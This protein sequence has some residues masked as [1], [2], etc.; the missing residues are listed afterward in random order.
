MARKFIKRFIPDSDW[1]KQQKSLQILGVW[2]HDPNIWHLTRHSVATAAFIGFFVAFIPL[3]SQMILAALLAVFLRANL[4]ISVALVWITNPLTMAPIYYIAYKVG[5]VIL[6]TP[7]EH[8]AFELSWDWLSSG[9]THNWQPFLLGCLLC[10]L[11]FGLLAS[12]MI[13]VAWRRHTVK[14]WHERRSIREA[15][16][17]NNSTH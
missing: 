6:N 5:A 4:A 17:S 16:K 7:P 2:I 8:F 9:V 13:H 15:R 3:P 14:R 12:T 1:I 10:G 11:F